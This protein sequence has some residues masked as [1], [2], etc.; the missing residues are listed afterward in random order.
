MCGITGYIDFNKNTTIGEL[1]KMRDTMLHRGPDDQGADTYNTEY[2]DIGLA[3]TRLSIIDLS[4]QGHQPMHYQQYTIILNGEIYNFSEIK[5]D[6]LNKGHQFVSTSDTEVV[7]HAFA[8]WGKSCVEYFIG[9]FAFIIYDRKKQQLFLCRDR[10]GIKPLYFY[11]KNGLIL[12]SSELKAFHQHPQFEKEIDEYAL[13]DFIQFGYIPGNQCIFKN[14][15]KIPPS[16]WMAIDLKTQEKVTTEYWSLLEQYRK[17]LLG[18]T[19][20]EAKDEVEK[21]IISASKYRMVSDVP[22]GVFLS[23]GYDSTLVTAILQKDNPEKLKTI[24]IGFPDGIDESKYAKQV[25]NHLGTEHTTYNCTHEDAQQIIPELPYFYDEPLA[26]I[27]AIP[28]ILVSQLARKNVTVALSADGG[29][30]LFAGYSWYASFVKRF[31]QLNSVPIVLQKSTGNLIQSLSYMVPENFFHVQHKLSGIKEF[32]QSKNDNRLVEL[33]YQSRHLA[34]TFN[35]KLFINAKSKKPIIFCN[36]YSKLNDSFASMLLVDYQMNLTD[37]LLVKVDRATMSASLEGREPL[38][39]H[40]LAE[41]AAQL[42]T[43]FKYDGKTHKRILRD[44]THKYVPKEIMDRPKVGFDLPVFDYLHKELAYL[45][46]EYL[47][48]K[49]IKESGYF[50]LQFVSI[51]VDQFK[52][53]KLLYKHI[54]WRLLM[55]Q[56]WYAKW[57]RYISR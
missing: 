11:E 43:Q 9:M 21:M 5:N 41:L 46:D 25:A 26:D 14:C 19:Y 12:F 54:I 24:T 27:S 10:A 39:D 2:A 1:K 33:M 16:S 36:S 37:C 56:M 28:S 6:L 38:M 42:S 47:S 48:E 20:N 51:L 55:F 50:N 23:G 29:D 22:V 52:T 49:A 34:E 8:Q 31:N 53:N 35:K 17:P 18:I 44:I 4:V 15:K 30:E 40:R 13:F 57:M 3:H 45:I 32:Y 7:L